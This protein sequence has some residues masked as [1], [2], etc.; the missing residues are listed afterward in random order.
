MSKRT[1]HSVVED[2][3]RIIFYY[4]IGNFHNLESFDFFCQSFHFEKKN[5]LKLQKTKKE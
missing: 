2:S 5:E 1:I 4:N 3:L